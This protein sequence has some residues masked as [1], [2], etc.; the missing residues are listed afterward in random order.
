[1][2][3]TEKTLGHMTFVLKYAW[4]RGEGKGAHMHVCIYGEN[5]F[6]NMWMTV[7]KN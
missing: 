5:V 7:L 6:L 1:M 2:P 3:G 4:V